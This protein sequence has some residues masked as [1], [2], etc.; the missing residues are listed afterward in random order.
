MK[1]FYEF[2]GNW[3]YIFDKLVGIITPS[4]ATRFSIWES[5]HLNQG[6]L[7]IV[8]EMELAGWE[9]NKGLNRI[10][11]S[12]FCNNY[13]SRMEEHVIHGYNE[14]GKN[15]KALFHQVLKKMAAMFWT[16]LCP[17]T[18]LIYWYTLHFQGLQKN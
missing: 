13:K 16:L 10:S 9:N 8:Y 5:K 3:F 14:F 2:K 12:E 6:H 11:E 1:T 7:L 15:K 17:S 4:N 18:S